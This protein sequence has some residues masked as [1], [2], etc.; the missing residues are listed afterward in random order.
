MYNTAGGFPDTLI[1]VNWHAEFTE[2]TTFW[3]EH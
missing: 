3:L 2:A 1:I